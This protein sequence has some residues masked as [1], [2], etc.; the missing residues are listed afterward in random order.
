M[1]LQY[2]SSWHINQCLLEPTDPLISVNNARWYLWIASMVILGITKRQCD[3]GSESSLSM[4]VVGGKM[5]DRL[6]VTCTDRPLSP[7]RRLVRRLTR[8]PNKCLDSVHYHY[9]LLDEWV[10]V[11]VWQQSVH[12]FLQKRIHIC[13]RLNLGRREP[14]SRPTGQRTSQVSS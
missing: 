2:G 6:S 13:L 12:A 10:I 5:M 1:P 14:S 3:D 11:C 4:R 7:T 8:R 9:T